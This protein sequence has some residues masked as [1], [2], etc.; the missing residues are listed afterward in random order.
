METRCKM[1]EIRKE[2]F[3]NTIE[4]VTY[5]VTGRT[6]DYLGKPKLTFYETK[7]TKM[8]DRGSVHVQGYKGTLCS[9]NKR[10]FPKIQEE[11]NR[12]YNGENLEELQRKFRK[13]HNIQP[14]RVG[15]TKLE[16]CNI[17]FSRKKGSKR[18]DAVTTFNKQRY[19]LCRCY[20]HEK[21][22]VKKDFNRMKKNPNFTIADIQ[23]RLGKKYNLR[24]PMKRHAP[25]TNARQ[26]TLTDHKITITDQGII[27]ID[28]QYAKTSPD[29]YR[30]V[31][32]IIQKD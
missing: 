17:S 21:P 5:K 15:I 19:K 22:Q 27:Y 29:L 6:P 20:E 13:E 1:K 32:T 28:G 24:Q 12:L 4:W 9:C 30:I 3:H 16:D 2:E 10:D 8:P 31:E 23:G 26:T 18:V 7:H 14:G 25:K 11:F